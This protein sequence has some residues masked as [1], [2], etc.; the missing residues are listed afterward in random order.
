[1][2]KSLDTI[3]ASVEPLTPRSDITRRNHFDCKQTAHDVLRFLNDKQIRLVLCCGMPEWKRDDFVAYL[4]QKRADT[5]IATADDHFMKDGAYVFN[6]KELTNAHIQCQQKVAHTIHNTT[7][8]CIVANQNST[9][10]NI[11]MYAKMRQ[12]FVIVAFV[13]D[14]K[15]TA[16]CLSLDNSKNMPSH[17]YERCFNDINGILPKLN[18]TTF[19]KLMALFNVIV[20]S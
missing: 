16:V 11:Q 20:T 1:M 5:V 2:S 6:P 14:T 4:K 18:Q 15:T 10:Q 8:I 7:S 12:P 17:I 13:P 3:F 9:V 19:P